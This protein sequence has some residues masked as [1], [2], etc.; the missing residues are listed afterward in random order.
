[1]SG[2]VSGKW[3]SGKVSGK[4][5]HARA[6]KR[7]SKGFCGLVGVF[8]RFFFR[9]EEYRYLIAGQR[10]RARRWMSGKDRCLEKISWKR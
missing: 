7:W 1:M 10:G 8:F 2:K 5:I 6:V 4:D 3:M 9:F